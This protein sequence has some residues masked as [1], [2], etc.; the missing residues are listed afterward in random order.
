MEQPSSTMSRTP[1]RESSIILSQTAILKC[2][3]SIGETKRTLISTCIT[4]LRDRSLHDYG[5][6]LDLKLA[7]TWQPD[8]EECNQWLLPTAPHSK[9]TVIWPQTTVRKWSV[10]GLPSTSAKPQEKPVAAKVAVFT[11]SART[12]VSPSH[13]GG[14]RS[15]VEWELTGAAI[16]SPLKRKIWNKD[17]LEHSW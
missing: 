14:S 13:R 7:G 8:K 5:F 6:T 3:R 17:L 10:A 12:K 2:Y 4:V 9:R 15:A 11:H 16:S 1:E